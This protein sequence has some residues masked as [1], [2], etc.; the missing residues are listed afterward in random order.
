[1]SGKYSGTQAHIRKKQPLA[2]YVHCG[3]HCV[4][5]IAQK[6]CTASIVVRDALDWV[7]Q[8][9][10]LCGQSGKFK[11]MFHTIA[12][13]D[14]GTSSALKPLCATRWTVR[15][16]A[17]HSVLTQYDSI[18]TALEEMAG[19]N[20]PTATTANG[21]FQQF[22][23][24]STVV[25]LVMAQAVIGEL[26][27]LNRSLQRRTETVSGM[28]AAVCKVQSTLNGK[29]SDE[30]FQHLFE[31]ASTVVN[32]VDLE[33]ITMPRVRQP[34]KCYGESSGFSPKTP[35]E[36]YRVEF[37][38]VL[39]TI[40]TQFTERFQ[41]GG[42]LTLQKL[43]NT[44]L[45]GN[46]DPVV[47]DYPEI[48]AQLLEIQLTMFKHNYMYRSCGEAT[49]II[50]ELPAEVRGLF[51]EV[52]TLMRLLLVVPVSS[53]EAERSF[54]ALRRLK[55][56]L[57]TSMSQQRLNHVAVCNIHQDKLDLL[58]KKSICAQFISFTPRRKQVFGAFM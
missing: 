51:T 53:S 15:H 56:W 39:D 45:S 36:Y 52:E 27:C 46:I 11:H 17:I 9:G 23:R 4:N 50:R 13:S 34:P 42:L 21:L 40:H 44:L 18:L 43:E 28:R 25:G 20:S 6:A 24:G 30:A 29:R 57:R 26:E 16:G 49:H 10:V 55:T 31:R 58:T 47:H 3:A 1:M 54:S 48:N 19:T 5:L 37:Y 33:P 14:H 35:I 41:Q 12:I 38:K 22:M 32:S 7:H 2:L 8:L